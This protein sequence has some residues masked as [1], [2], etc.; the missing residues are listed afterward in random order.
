MACDTNTR[1]F[2]GLFVFKSTLKYSKER[3]I[4]L[5]SLQVTSCCRSCSSAVL[6]ALRV[7]EEG[8]EAEE[9]RQVRRC[10]VA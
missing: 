4:R 10:N 2:L 5:S 1:V 6:M 8:E 3:A 9:D 7:E